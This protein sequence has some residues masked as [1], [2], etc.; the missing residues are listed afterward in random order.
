MITRHALALILSVASLS[1]SAKVLPKSLAFDG[2]C[3][4]LINITVSDTGWVTATHDYSDCPQSY[5]STILGGVPAKAVAGVAGRAVSFTEAS[6]ADW[7]YTFA[8]YVN[9]DHTL[10]YAVVELGGIGYVGTWTEGYPKG[11][12]RAEKTLFQTAVPSHR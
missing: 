7:G 1:V 3:D 12:L 4:G 8:M 11:K 10:E 2:V 6:Y 5:N 9:A